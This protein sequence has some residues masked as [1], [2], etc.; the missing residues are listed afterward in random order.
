MAAPGT[1]DVLALAKFAYQVYDTYR[2]APQRFHALCEDINGLVLVLK[3]LGNRLALQKLDAND[4][5]VQV[6]SSENADLEHLTQ[7]IGR[8]LDEL[9]RKRGS[10]SAPRGLN[11][12]K[13]SQGEV[14][15][16]RSR[17]TS[18]CGIIAAFNT[19]ILVLPDISSAPP[20]N[21]YLGRSQF[22]S[23]NVT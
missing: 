12:F 21:V 8:L 6:D 3:Q 9:Q 5:K 14:D 13:W 19:S 2:N 16:F 1:P 20:R 18:L 23:A 11:R 10:S 4:P 17:I 22:A 15:S 7:Q